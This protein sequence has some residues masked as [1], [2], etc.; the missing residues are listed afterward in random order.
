MI[1]IIQPDKID[2]LRETIIIIVG[3]II[4]WFEK[5]KIKDGKL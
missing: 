1:E 5:K 4:R 2:L 3:L